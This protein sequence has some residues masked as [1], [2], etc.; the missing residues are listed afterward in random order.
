[1]NALR[2]LLVLGIT[3]SGL[4]ASAAERPLVVR[5]AKGV[6][7]IYLFPFVALWRHDQ[8][9][10]VGPKQLYSLAISQWLN[11]PELISQTGDSAIKSLVNAVITLGV[12]SGK[13]ILY[14]RGSDPSASDFTDTERYFVIVS[15]R[16]Y[17]FREQKP[18]LAFLRQHCQIADPKPVDV[19]TVFARLSKRA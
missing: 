8:P 14:G 1:V 10:D 12:D 9:L 2:L 18:W 3:S 16:V 15:D 13:R 6:G 7:I 11:E 19:E 5:S 17:Y 4:V